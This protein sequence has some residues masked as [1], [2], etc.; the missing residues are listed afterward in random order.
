MGVEETVAWICRLDNAQYR[1][2]KDKLKTGLAERIDT[3]DDLTL[4]DMV[5]LNEIGI[6][7]IRD[8]KKILGH[9]KRLQHIEG[10]IPDQSA[11]EEVQD[12]PFSSAVSPLPSANMQQK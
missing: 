5:T 7:K 1:H 10:G 4:L 8:R 12:Q 3:G 9:V 6:L 2:Y 11:A